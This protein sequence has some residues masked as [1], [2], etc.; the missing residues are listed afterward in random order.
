[1]TLYSLF[2]ALSSSQTS[3]QVYLSYFEIY[4]EQIFDL[5]DA[6]CTNASGLS[7]GKS[8]RSKSKKRLREPKALGL[9]TDKNRKT[10]IQDLREVAC[11]G[12]K[13]ALKVFQTGET[14]RKFAV[15]EMNHN[16]SRS[17]VIFQIR[18]DLRMYK[19]NFVRKN[20][21]ILILDLAGSES[22]RRTG[23]DSKKQLKESSNINKSLLALTRVISQLNKVSSEVTPASAFDQLPRLEVDSD[24][25][26]RV[27]RGQSHFG[28]LQREPGQ[29]ELERVFVDSP[30]RNSG[31]VAKTEHRK[32]SFIRGGKDGRV[33]D[34]QHGQRRTAQGNPV[35]EKCHFGVGVQ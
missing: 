14:R 20:P 2:R 5:L 18:V 21:K 35:A 10:V 15:T 7:P 30:V 34:A 29:A 31:G 23:L 25:E 32:G 9:R 12:W 33:E 8:D 4:N 17:H 1:M 16:S 24:F 27:D 22:I 28:D 3:Y 26:G 11:K 6:D 19:T 13:D